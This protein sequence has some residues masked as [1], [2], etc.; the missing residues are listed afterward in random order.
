MHNCKLT[1]HIKVVRLTLTLHISDVKLAVS[2]LVGWAKELGPSRA[3][4]CALE[5]VGK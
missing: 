2:Y 4:I 1:G 3:A 5:C